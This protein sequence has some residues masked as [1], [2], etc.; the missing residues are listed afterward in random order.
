[1]ITV[2]Q[3]VRLLG[4]R[5]DELMTHAPGRVDV[6]KLHNIDD[7]RLLRECRATLDRTELFT[8]QQAVVELR[9]HLAGVEAAAPPIR[10]TLSQ[11][12]SRAFDSITGQ[13][14]DNS[15]FAQTPV[16]AIPTPEPP[17]K[18]LLDAAEAWLIAT[19]AADRSDIDADALTRPWVEATVRS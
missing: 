11:R 6:A 18:A 9:A 7:V 10:P 5:A 4:E 13:T 14:R 2:D 1:M 15:R 17:P 3:A 8:V 16:G 19:I 12:M